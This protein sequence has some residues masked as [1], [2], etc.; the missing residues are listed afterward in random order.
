MLSFPRSEES[1]VTFADELKKKFRQTLDD[2]EDSD[3]SDFEELPPPDVDALLKPPMTRHVSVPIFPVATMPCNIQKRIPR[4]S[5]LPSLSSANGRSNDNPSPLPPPP[6][7]TI[8]SPNLSP[9]H[10]KPV[11]PPKP[12]IS[13]PLPSSQLSPVSEF[14]LPPPPLPISNDYPPPRPHKSK[15]VMKQQSE[16]LTDN[17]DDHYEPMSPGVLRVIFFSLHVLFWCSML[18]SNV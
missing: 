17:Y 11:P 4:N 1:P 9:N 12:I 16:A 13:S 2:R 5:T 3:A 8:L 18:H 6:P 14:P 7:H 15:Y 10:P